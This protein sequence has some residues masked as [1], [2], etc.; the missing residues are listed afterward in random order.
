MTRQRAENK[1]VQGAEN[2]MRTTRRYCFTCPVCGTT[3]ETAEAAPA[4]TCV[5]GP[6][7]HHDE[8]VMRRDWKAESVGIGSGVRVS[9]SAIANHDP[10]RPLPRGF[11]AR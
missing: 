2:K 4:P 8:T 5:D 7:H 3:V 10:S 6:T 9:R 1:A 11:K